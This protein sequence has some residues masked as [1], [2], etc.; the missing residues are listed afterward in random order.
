MSTS[1]QKKQQPKSVARTKQWM[2]CIMLLSMAGY[3]FKVLW[4]GVDAP[5]TRTS[6]FADTSTTPDKSEMVLIP[7]GRFKMGSMDEDLPDSKPMH[8]AQV[9]SFLLDA[10]PVTNIQFKMFISATEYVTTAEQIGHGKVF[11]PAAN[12]WNTVQGAS[13]IHPHGLG[14]SISGRDNFPVVQVSWY[15]ANAYAQWAGKRLPTEA[16]Y[17]YA[18]KCRL[19]NSVYPWGEEEK[20]DHKYMANYWQGRFPLE[21]LGR[22]GFRTIAPV[23]SFSK[24]EFKLYDMS[25]N[26]WCWCSDWYASDAYL[27]GS[28]NNPTG[29]KVGTDHVLRG[30]SWLSNKFYL[31][32]IKCAARW[33]AGPEFR[34]NE[35]GF[36]CAK[37]Q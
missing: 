29:P 14:S 8:H 30:G 16:E 24:N 9:N 23:A 28:H 25:G 22:D 10:T 5:P 1:K 17:E 35:I 21:D 7:G 18:A 36:R 3:G 32:G 34:S 26:A 37:D 20:I 4:Y 33:H 31:S 27:H 2:A 11:D 19:A 15:D 13:W 12:K 6:I